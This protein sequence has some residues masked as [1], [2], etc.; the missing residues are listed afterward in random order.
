MDRHP[1]SGYFTE[2]L[3]LKSFPDYID[4]LPKGAIV[5]KINVMGDIPV[6][7]ISTYPYVAISEEEY[8]YY[9]DRS[10]ALTVKAIERKGYF[11]V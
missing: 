11:A 1:A 4:Y 2:I 7:E 5:R 8:T 3:K 9:V 6:R 10:V